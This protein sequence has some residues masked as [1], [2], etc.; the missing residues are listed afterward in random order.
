MSTA[1][2]PLPAASAA[3]GAGPPP[4]TAR[5]WPGATRRDAAWLGLAWLVVLA[6]DFSGA[7]LAVSRTVG[8]PDGF[9]LRD[10]WLLSTVLHTGGRWAAWGLWLGLAL[11][12][13]RT[14]PDGRPA[15]GGH[16]A[17][18]ARHE[19]IAAVLAVLGASWLVPSLKRLS[20]SSCPWDL[21]GFGGTGNWV[22]HWLPGVVDGGPGGCF[23]SGHAVAAFAFIPAVLLWRRARPGEARRA[24]WAIAVVGSVFGLVQMVRGAHFV[25][26]TA[27]SAWLCG[28]WGLLCLEAHARWANGRRHR[29]PGPPGK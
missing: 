20:R 24:A 27:W 18:P 1:P 6:W 8:G 15:H 3:P 4:P 7:D 17:S 21:A 13:W 10:H 9:P 28:A 2:D 22:P 29:W 14:R 26:H 19:R 25:S 5:H 11:D 16:T 23:P 12:A